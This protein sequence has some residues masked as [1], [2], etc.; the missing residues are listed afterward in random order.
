LAFF[1]RLPLPSLLLQASVYLKLILLH[2]PF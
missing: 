2:N 1:T